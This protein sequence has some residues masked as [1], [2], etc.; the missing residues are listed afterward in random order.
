MRMMNH[1]ALNKIQEQKS[2]K[3]IALVGSMHMNTIHENNGFGMKGQTTP[4]LA[5][6][7]GAAAVAVYDA[8]PGDPG[9]LQRGYQANESNEDNVKTRFD[10][11]LALP[12]QTTG[13]TH[14]EIAKQT[15][16][17]PLS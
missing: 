16:L 10:H 4:G 6:L 17:N 9:S 3:W 5:E 12:Q 1:L 14:V 13:Q 11:F 7:T 2:G 8:K 15:M